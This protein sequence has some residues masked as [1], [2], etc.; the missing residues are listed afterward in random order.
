[1]L[2][3]KLSIIR[4]KRLINRF[5]AFATKV[6]YNESIKKGLITWQRF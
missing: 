2:F 6:V 3:V 5:V 1:M 4:P